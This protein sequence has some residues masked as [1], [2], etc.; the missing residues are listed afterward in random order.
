MKYRLLGNTG[1]RVSTYS[2]GSVMFGSW[3][4]DDQEQC[5]AMIHRALDAGINLIDTADVY[6]QGQS[7]RIIG[8]ALAGR[9]DEVLLA[10]KVHGPMGTG[11]NER[12]NSRSWIMRA[13]EAS[14]RR[15]ETDYLDL[16]QLHRPDPDTAIDETLAAFDDLVRQGKVR[17]VGTSTFAAWQ[18]VEAQAASA[19]R[20]GTRFVCEQAPYSLLVRSIERDVLAVAEHYR[21]GVLAWSPLAGGWL[22]GRYR[23]DQPPPPQSRAERVQEYRPRGGRMA[24]RYDLNNDAN[25]AKFSVIESLAALASD[26]GLTMVDLSLAFTLAHPAVTSTIIGPRTLDQIDGILAGADIRLD[27][28]TLDA[29]DAIIEPGSVLNPA[30]LGWEPP[31][32]TPTFRRTQPT[33]Y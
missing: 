1:L 31:W 23:R 28:A 24:D 13:V 9:R 15:L 29:I 25:D 20:A 8:K 11:A 21:L 10:T 22:A 2:L 12:G 6:G 30:D 4:N 19:A 26:R 27:D 33:E 5:A 16:Y 7:E 32:L 3:G 17:Y 18:L 14:L